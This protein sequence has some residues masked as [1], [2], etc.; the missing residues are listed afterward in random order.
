MAHYR[1][2]ICCVHSIFSVWSK[3]KSWGV[4][5]GHHCVYSLP[6]FLDFCVPPSRPMEF[7]LPSAPSPFSNRYPCLW[8]HID[9]GISEGLFY[10]RLE[11]KHDTGPL[12]DSC[13][14][15]PLTSSELGFIWEKCRSKR[16]TCNRY[17]AFVGPQ[18]RGAAEIL[19]LY[20]QPNQAL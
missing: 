1:E 19:R 17:S 3:T 18:V 16:I 14:L 2:R 15:I 11:T 4:Q 5:V 13:S 10:Q 6:V 7:Y 12:T 8:K 9:V 20:L